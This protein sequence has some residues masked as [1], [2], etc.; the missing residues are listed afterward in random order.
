MENSAEIFEKIN[1]FLQPVS[2][3]LIFLFTKSTGYLIL[4]TFSLLYLILS[5]ANALK[6]RKLA[7]RAANTNYVPFS[8]I[9]YITGSQI[10]KIGL[11]IISNLPVLLITVLLLL[12]IVGLSTT[13]QKVDE[14]IENQERIKELQ[15]TLK[16]LNQRYI[17]ATIEILEI[18]DLSD[19]TKLEVSFFDNEKNDYL[20]EKQQ[21][22]IAGQDIYFL[23]FVLNFEYSEIENGDKKNIVVPYK[24]FSEK[25]SSSEGIILDIKDDNGIPYIFHRSEEDVYGIDLE[26]YNER[27]KDIAV[28][29]TDDVKAKEAG[30]KSFYE[31]AVHNF[32]A[33]K[34]GQKI[35]IW[36]EQT[37]GIVIKEEVDF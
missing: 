30:V 28:L 27:L 6:V 34:T 19:R 12:G 20:E 32:K 3:I 24:I 31:A 8:E 36:V 18:D 11:K 35:T 10:V 29:M 4:I 23:S 25:V 37:G 13:F 14:F 15:I 9:I 5:V 17:V 26:T 1:W 22:T 7:H 16:N 33:L 2:D 21:I